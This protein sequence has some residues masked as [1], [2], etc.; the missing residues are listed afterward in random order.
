M[1]KFNKIFFISILIFSLN[2]LL[3]YS[4]ENKIIQED[5]ILFDRAKY[6]MLIN[7]FE[8]AIKDIKKI[9]NSEIKGKRALTGEIYFKLEKYKEAKKEFY[10]VFKNDKKNDSIYLMFLKTLI[11]LKEYNEINKNMQ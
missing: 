10:Y 2:Y 1:I 8:G 11:K 7:D 5:K 4:K 3:N 6:K 9:K